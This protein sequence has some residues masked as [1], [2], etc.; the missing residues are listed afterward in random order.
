MLIYSF[1]YSSSIHL[2]MPHR[3]IYPSI[4]LQSIF[5]PLTPCFPFFF[6]S[7]PS[8][9]IFTLFYVHERFAWMSV[10]VPHTWL[11]LMEFRGG[12]RYPGTGVMNVCEPPH[13]CWEL[14][15]APLQA[16]VLGDLSSS[17]TLLI[18]QSTSPSIH[19]FSSVCTINISRL[20]N[21][22]STRVFSFCPFL[23]PS[24]IQG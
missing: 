1:I 13:W 12:I 14:S 2:F 5:N 19:L 24:S 7:F 16:Q 15:P 9:K 3:I 22:L 17:L 6:H 18:H 10:C 4:H 21:F 8:F 11:V 20:C 23:H